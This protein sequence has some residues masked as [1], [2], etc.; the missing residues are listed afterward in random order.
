[1]MIRLRQ[2]DGRASGNPPI[3]GYCGEMPS[4]GHSMVIWFD[5]GTVSA[6][7]R[8]GPVQHIEYTHDGLHR[9]VVTTKNGV[10]D[11]VRLSAMY[12]SENLVQGE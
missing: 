12:L 11:A 5:T 3:R 1:M 4:V 9:M 7:C 8:T 2:V 6:Y 10:Y